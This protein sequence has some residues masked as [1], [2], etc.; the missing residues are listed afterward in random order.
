MGEEVMPA[1]VAP[2]GFQAQEGFVAGGGPEL[3]GAFEPALILPAG[4]F[5]GP[6][7]QR[8]VGQEELLGRGG[9]LV[10]GLTR[11][12]DL[13]VAHPVGVVL[14]VLDLGLEFFLLGLEES[15]FEFGQGGDDVRGLVA[16]D[17]LEQ[18]SDPGPGLRGVA[19]ME[20]M[21]DGPEM[22]VG[23]VEVQLLG[24]GGEAVLDQVPDPDR[25]VGDHQDALGLTQAAPDGLVMEL[26]HEGLEAQA[27]GDIAALGDDGPMAGGLSAMVEAKDGGQ[28]NPM[29]AAGGLAL[30]PERLGVAPVIPFADVPGI[31][32]DDQREGLR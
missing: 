7:A 21:G 3:A 27:G 2:E 16:A 25:P 31:D 12:E 24:G 11:F 5:D 6:G 32:F 17:L 1:A 4:G 26:G 30:G 8:L 18:G 9:A 15:G 19:A 23:V 29:P 14:E 22:F 13:A 28:V 10:A 20:F